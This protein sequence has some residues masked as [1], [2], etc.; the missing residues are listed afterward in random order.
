[1]KKISF[2]LFIIMALILTACA[3]PAGAATQANS[4]QAAGD[5]NIN[6]NVP[7]SPASKLA[8]GTLKLKTTSY[9]VT[10]EQATTLLPL[11]EGL[12]SLSQSTTF[13]QVEYDALV[14]QIQDSMT[15]DQT[16]AIAGMNLYPGGYWQDHAGAGPGQRV[17]SRGK[18]QRYANCPN[19]WRQTRCNRWGRWRW[20]W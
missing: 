5:P 12:R 7:L 1:M 19:S 2:A 20:W 16:N 13:S 3:T 6:S 18:C 17:R 8:L 15:P 9:A 11:W 4:T 14:K 10:A